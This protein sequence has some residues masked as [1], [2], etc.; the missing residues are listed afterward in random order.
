MQIIHNKPSNSL[1]GLSTNERKIISTINLSNKTIVQSSDIVE[2]FDISSQKANIILSRLC[3]KGWLQRIKRGSYI[4]IPLESNSTQPLS[5][6]NWSMAS[7]LFSPCYLS[8]WTAAEYWNLT[9]QI[10]NTIVA[11]T[12]SPQR[13][14]EHTIA[15]IRYRTNQINSKNI[16]GTK[17]LWINNKQ[18]LIA[19]I[20][21]TLVD[22]LMYPSIGGGGEHVVK[23]AKNYWKNKEADP[24]KLLE[25]SLRI[26][27]GVLFKR[28]GYTAEIFGSVPN[29]W[30][31]DLRSRISQGISKFDPTSPDKGKILT[32]WHLRY[33]APTINV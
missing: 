23:I 21:K 18:V 25:Y 22:V 29:D 24:N 33:N 6:E 14:S 7:E 2:R 28:L 27:K 12:A 26:N 1:A 20:H 31:D 17:K 15:G 11:F 5:E 19:D 9:E 3:K 32:R 10:F 8:G 30:L 4:L 13:K 16:F